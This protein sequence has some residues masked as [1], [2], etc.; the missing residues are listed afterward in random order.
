MD[1]P[2]KAKPLL[3]ELTVNEKNDSILI[4]LRNDHKVIKIVPSYIDVYS[5]VQNNNKMEEVSK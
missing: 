4:S 3:L 5:L 2:K 1:S